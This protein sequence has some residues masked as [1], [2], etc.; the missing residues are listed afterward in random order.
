MSS[1]VRNRGLMPDLA[2]AF[3]T[4]EQA[5]GTQ[6]IAW[7][8]QD[9][10]AKEGFFTVTSAGQGEA[11]D[12]HAY[13]K[14]TLYLD[15]GATFKKEDISDVIRG[16]M[17]PKRGTAEMPSI[18]NTAKKAKDTLETDPYNMDFISK[19]GLVYANEHQHE[20]AANVMIRGWKR[21]SELK[22]PN[23]RF[24]FMLKLSEVSFRNRQFKQAYAVI[25]DI[26]EP[27]DPKEKLAYQLLFC[28]V[29]AEAGEAP[30]ALSIF[31]KAVEKEDFEMAVKILASCCLRL[32]HVGSFQAAK[33]TV[34][35]KARTGQMNAM[36][37]ARLDTIEGWTKERVEKVKSPWSFDDG[38]PAWAPKAGL[39]FV[40]MIIIYLLWWMESKSLKS[41]KIGPA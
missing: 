28:H 9:E 38:M 11:V 19:L 37:I 36:D 39:A 30:K 16:S 33:N 17:L 10:K 14:F 34:A 35:Q 40:C 25:M 27:R 1:Q 31:S 32:S 12:I 6:E 24:R 20:K 18:S 3:Q 41:L 5:P 21:A 13:G 8:L 7:R 29:A 23:E 2:A 4:P 26:E 15:G 22:D